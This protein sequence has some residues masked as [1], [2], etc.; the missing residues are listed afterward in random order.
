MS[1]TY[2]GVVSDVEAISEAVHEKGIPL[3]VDEAH[4]AHFGFHPYFPENANRSGADIVIHSLHKTL[5]SLTQT[6]L[7]HMNEIFAHV[8]E[9]QSVLCVDGKYRFLYRSVGEPEG[10]AFSSVCPKTGEASVKAFG[11]SKA[12]S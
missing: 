3:I 1:P 2:D 9:Q 7:L 8:T 4:G 10:G 5:P 6:A 12:A 11:A